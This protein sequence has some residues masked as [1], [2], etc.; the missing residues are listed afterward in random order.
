[1][2]SDGPS[3]TCWMVH[4]IT[5]SGGVAALYGAL[6]W[7]IRPADLVRVPPTLGMAMPWQRSANQALDL[8]PHR[9]RSKRSKTWILS[10]SYRDCPALGGGIRFTALIILINI[11]FENNAFVNTLLIEFLKCCR[12]TELIYLC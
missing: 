6:L 8:G 1:M 7:G 10:T 3:C 5:A 2:A 12:Y 9:L 11:I 4:G